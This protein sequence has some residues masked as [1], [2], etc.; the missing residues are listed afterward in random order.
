MV[1]RINYSLILR[2][3]KQGE[4][5][6]SISKKYG[7]SF[8]NL[9]INLKEL[10]NYE[11]ELYIRGKVIDKYNNF[12][13]RKAP[14]NHANRIET[15]ITK[16]A[17]KILI[18]KYD[19]IEEVCVWNG[20]PLIRNCVDLYS[21]KNKLAIEI[22]WRS[23]ETIKQLLKKLSKYKLLFGK[24]LCVLVCNGNNPIL[25]CER[26]RNKGFEVELLFIEQPSPYE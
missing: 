13:I 2:D 15:N 22:I 9:S 20:E 10:H 7:H 1:K 24:V 11:F 25:K 21:I 18:K 8:R 17:K 19:C 6:K 3:L 23:S 26:L 5:L 14:P 4:S 16:K 12:L